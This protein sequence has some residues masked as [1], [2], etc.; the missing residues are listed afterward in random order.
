MRS[1]NFNSNNPAQTKSSRG[2]NIKIFKLVKVENGLE[3]INGQGNIEFT[4]DQENG[5]PFNISFALQEDD[6]KID[7]N[8][9]TGCNPSFIISNKLYEEKSFID[10]KDESIRKINDIFLESN[11][12]EF[13]Q[14]IIVDD[15]IPKDDKK[16]FINCMLDDEILIV[17]ND[18]ESTRKIE[19]SSYKEL[20]GNSKSLDNQVSI[21]PK[22]QENKPT[23]DD[24]FN[25][26]KDK[27][28]ERLGKLAKLT[29]NGATNG[30][31]PIPIIKKDNGII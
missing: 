27:I 15:G 14:I 22:N 31:E 28:F 23:E 6:L 29:P 2:I 20:N 16:E 21:T 18:S 3:Y 24:N 5:N 10:I 17:N 12:D 11:K 8:K 26:K 4:K 30:S 19:N 13:K 25:K 9:G 7:S 1:N